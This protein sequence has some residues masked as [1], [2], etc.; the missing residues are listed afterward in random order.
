MVV[1]VHNYNNTFEI[2][3]S[4]RE[5]EIE[6]TIKLDKTERLHEKEFRMKM[7]IDLKKVADGEGNLQ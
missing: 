7:E 1:H 3:R 4:V 2:K 5:A 6:S